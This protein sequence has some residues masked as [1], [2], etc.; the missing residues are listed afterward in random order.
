MNYYNTIYKLHNEIVKNLMR[1]QN[2]FYTN[3]FIIKFL[4]KLKTSSKY[5]HKQ[6]IF[7]YTYEI[8]IIKIL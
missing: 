2:R 5:I 4:K 6:C 7:I 3:F 8:C 1:I